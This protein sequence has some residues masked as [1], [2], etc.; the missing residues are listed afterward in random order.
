MNISEAN[1]H[2]QELN[3]LRKAGVITEEEYMR[4]ISQMNQK[5]T[6]DYYDFCMEVCNILNTDFVLG[7]IIKFTPTEV[8]EMLEKHKNQLLPFL[9]D[10]I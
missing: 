5:C 3:S 8:A 10:G 7:N 9:K 2:E 1:V 4:F 6:P